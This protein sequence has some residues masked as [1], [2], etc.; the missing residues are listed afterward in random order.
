MLTIT[1]LKWGSKRAVPLRISNYQIKLE[2][3]NQFS[4]TEIK[5]V[6]VNPNDFEV[7]GV[8][9]FP[10]ADDAMISGIALSINDRYVRGKILTADRAR[11]VYMESAKHAENEPVLK[12]IG[13]RAYV[14]RVGR[15]PAK[16]E[17][18][19]RF[20]YSQ[21]LSV[22]SVFAKYTH[23]LSLA[24]ATQA[25]IEYF[26]VNINIKSD[27]DI[28]RICLPSH[29]IVVDDKWQ[30]DYAETDLDPDRD[31][32]FEYTVSDPRF[33]IGLIAHRTSADSVGFFKLFIAPRYE[34]QIP[35]LSPKKFIF[36]LD[37]SEGMSGEKIRRAKEVL[38]KS[39]YNLTFQDEFNILACN[40]DIASL[41]TN[42]GR[43]EPFAPVIFDNFFNVRHERKRAL[44]FIENIEASG[45]T[46]INDALLTAL[47]GNHQR[48]IVLLTD[49]GTGAMNAPRIL[50]NIAEAN[51]DQAR[52]FVIGVGDGPNVH[53]LDRLAVDNGGTYR[54]LEPNEDIEVAVSS[55]FREINDPVLTNIKIDFGDI[56]VENV[57]P[58]PQELP[59]LFSHEQL[60][61][62]GRYRGHGD[63]RL[64]LSGFI[65]GKEHEFTKNVH[66]SE[67]QSRFDFLSHLWA[68]VKVK[69]LED[70]VG[71]SE[72][73]SEL[74][75]EIKRL[76]KAYGVLTPYTEDDI[77]VGLPIQ[78]LHADT[79]RPRPVKSN[80]ANLKRKRV[81]Q[82]RQ[83]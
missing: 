33:G 5:Q 65:N 78:R 69:A 32:S 6:F 9:I 42:N 4:S 80:R 29:G 74:I 49:D 75:K 26:R 1:R 2:I 21:M 28:Q 45:E 54:H 40:G 59:D 82:V 22:A 17:L 23:P 43:E 39:I 11:H 48:I 24:K 7:D 53:F 58:H 37:R 60:T 41:N 72:S 13:T 35:D 34:N 68:Q 62:V 3:K 38:R 79:P 18:Q 20:T 70:E 66:F 27:L 56:A 51:A 31:F 57:Y 47:N 15:I 77:P 36:V 55:L 63:T 52:I 44:T 76:S 16:G 25:C 61:L 71:R 64:K 19:I 83:N 73:N 81:L 8:Y 12:Y 10:L 30:I 67:F 46:N 50:E 14:V